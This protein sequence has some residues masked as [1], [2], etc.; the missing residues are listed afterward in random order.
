MPGK[1][2]Q[3][4]VVYQASVESANGKVETYVGLSNNFNKRSLLDKNVD[5][6][7]A[8]STHY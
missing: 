7:N 6:G 4:G 5:G 2:N 8:L 1:C 3:D